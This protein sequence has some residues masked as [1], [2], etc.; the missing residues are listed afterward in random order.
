MFVKK[1]SACDALVANDGCEI[2][3]LLHPKNDPVDLSYSLVIATVAIGQQSYQHKLEQT[4][5]S[6][7]CRAMVD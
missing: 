1:S 7:Y 2:R 3:E 5:V 6:T 4:E